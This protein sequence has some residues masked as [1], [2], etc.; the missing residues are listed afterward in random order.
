MSK[1]DIK[2]VEVPLRDFIKYKDFFLSLYAHIREYPKNLEAYTSCIKPMKDII[3]VHKDTLKSFMEAVQKAKTE[4]HKK[5]LDNEFNEYINSV[6]K[7][8]L[9]P[10]TEEEIK[11]KS[12]DPH[13]IG[14]IEDICP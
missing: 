6:I 13:M 4:E 12:L 11:N 5:E 10:L 3:D 2:V 8:E 9:I 7:I 1:L 14:L